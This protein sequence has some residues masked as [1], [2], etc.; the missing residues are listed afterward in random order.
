MAR[1]AEGG[2]LDGQKLAEHLDGEKLAERLVRDRPPVQRAVDVAVPIRVAWRE[3][4]TLERLPEGTDVVTGIERD[5]DGRLM[6][7]IGSRP[8]KAQVLDQRPEESFAWQSS[9]GSDCAGLLTF[10]EL[11]E[12]LTR[13][14]LSLDLAPHRAFEALLIACRAADRRAEAELRRFKARVELIS[15]DVY[16]QEEEP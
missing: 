2:L 8:W 10:H 6:G 4:M 15:P 11:G 9:E 3:W 1:F 12:R 13:I 14:E 7:R 16:D 5:G